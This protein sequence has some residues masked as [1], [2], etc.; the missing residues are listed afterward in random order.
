MAPQ[1]EK[2]SS[3]ANSGEK[4][5]QKSLMAF[6]NKAAPASAT[7]S[8]KP[9]AQEPAKQPRTTSTSKNREIETRYTDILDTTATPVKGSS[10]QS[11]VESPHGTRNSNVPSS[12][13][14]TPPTSDIIDVDMVD[15]EESAVDEQKGDTKPVSTHY[16]VI[17]GGAQ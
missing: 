15:D 14:E 13:V 7:T 1:G 17:V 12:P 10:Q 16:F 8:A 2:T 6:F 4:M 11:A 9:K 3:K 5:K